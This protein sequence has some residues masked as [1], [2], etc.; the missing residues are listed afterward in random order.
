MKVIPHEWPFTSFPKLD[1]N[2][3]GLLAEQLLMAPTCLKYAR[4][5]VA[6]SPGM[7]VWQQL[8]IPAAFQC[9]VH[10]QEVARGNS[11]S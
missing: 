4:E 7:L 9:Q 3:P 5:A 1:S 11:P 8:E 2:V 6:R 10:S